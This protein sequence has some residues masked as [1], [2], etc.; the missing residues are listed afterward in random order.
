MVCL[1]FC[2]ERIHTHTHSFS[3]FFHYPFFLLPLS[4][5]SLCLSHCFNKMKKRNTRKKRGKEQESEIKLALNEMA[6]KKTV[7]EIDEALV[8]IILFALISLYLTHI[9]H[10]PSLSHSLSLHSCVKF[11][12]CV[13]VC[14]YE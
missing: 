2:C 9:L 14:V 3:S 4:S 11:V 5:E 6:S 12:Y 13:C 7:I 8:C 1:C 10:G